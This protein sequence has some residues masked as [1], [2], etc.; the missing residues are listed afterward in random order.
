MA[1]AARRAGTAVEAMAAAEAIAAE[2]GAE[3]VVA[4][5]GAETETQSSGRYN[6]FTRVNSSTTVLFP[7][8]RT[9]CSHRHAVPSRSIENKL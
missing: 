1:V 4:G 9:V 7:K 3:V 2:A 8:P 5:A 6:S